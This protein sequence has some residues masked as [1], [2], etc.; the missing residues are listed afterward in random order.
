[1]LAVCYYKQL[2]STLYLYCRTSDAGVTSNE[3]VELR[4]AI[5][6]LETIKFT[7]IVLWNMTPCSRYQYL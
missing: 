1:M 4:V 7:L 2:L 6:M 5:L 3:K